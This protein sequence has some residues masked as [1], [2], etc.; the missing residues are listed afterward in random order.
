MRNLDELFPFI[1][2]GKVKIL[3]TI[4][5]VTYSFILFILT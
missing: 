2:L 5:L 1:K 4:F 3:S